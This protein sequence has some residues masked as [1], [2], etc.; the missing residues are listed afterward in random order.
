MND[1]TISVAS[2]VADLDDQ[3]RELAEQAAEATGDERRYLM[4][5]GKRT[6]R[7]RNA[8]RWLRDEHDCEEI[9][10]AGLTGGEVARLEDAAD[11]GESGKQRV[12]RVCLGSEAAPW[13]V[14]GVDDFADEQQKRVAELPDGLL[15]YLASR[16]T[17]LSDPL[18]GQG[19]EQSFEELLREQ[20]TDDLKPSNDA[21]S[22][23]RPQTEPTPRST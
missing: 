5:I 18:G 7:M 13:V 2:A 11:S 19:N 17:D 8:L 12:L 20:A 3:R 10:L 21:P 15:K 9:T 6:D 1:E 23:E 4:E 16:I 14:D 22:G